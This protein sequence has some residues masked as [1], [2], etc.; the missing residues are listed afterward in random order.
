[1]SDSQPRQRR[2]P[3]CDAPLNELLQPVCSACGSDAETFGNKCKHDVDLSTICEMC[4]YDVRRDEHNQP[5]PE[6][7]EYKQG[8]PPNVCNLAFCGQPKEAGIHAVKDYGRMAQ[9]L[10]ESLNSPSAQATAESV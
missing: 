5:R 1:M 6:R 8:I 7:H 2:S 9:A 4:D 10:N 3:C